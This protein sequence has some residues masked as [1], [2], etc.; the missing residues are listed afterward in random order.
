MPATLL[1]PAALDQAAARLT[2]APLAPAEAE[3]WRGIT[4]SYQRT[5]PADRD[6]RNMLGGKTVDELIH[7][8]GITTHGQ[9]PPIE[10]RMPGRLGGILPGRLNRNKR[11]L[12][13]PPSTVL[14]A[15]A[16][17][18]EEYG[19]QAR[20]HHL[21]DARGRRCVCGAIAAA[22]DLGVGG[23]DA[24]HGAAGHVLAELRD[25][26]WPHPHLIGDWNQVAGRTPQQAIQLI[27]AARARAINAGQ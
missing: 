11:D 25:R 16:R 27:H 10:I 15:A 1:T 17:V 6:A 26:S 23:I 2:P 9:R 18:L 3:A 22:Y 13:Q 14:Y 5:A 20:P 12:S 24:A 19:W 8:A 7:E 4:T 21:R